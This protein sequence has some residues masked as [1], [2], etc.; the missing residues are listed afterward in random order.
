MNNRKRLEE[1]VEIAKEDSAFVHIKSRL[2]DEKPSKPRDMRDLNELLSRHHDNM[3]ES[4]L[5][6]EYP[7]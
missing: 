3:G 6:K 4:V 1:L 5:N 7:L 2:S